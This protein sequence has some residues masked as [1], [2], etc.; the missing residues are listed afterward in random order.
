MMSLLARKA[1]LLPGLCKKPLHFKALS[2]G[3]VRWSAGGVSSVVAHSS[4]TEVSAQKEDPRVKNQE[5]NGSSV[6]RNKA[7]PTFQ[8]AIAK[9]QDYWAS[10]GCA[11]WLPHNTEVQR[12]E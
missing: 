10:V 8:E 2:L 12:V 3:N 1:L 5:E 4:S 9:L 6:T 11:V 7:A